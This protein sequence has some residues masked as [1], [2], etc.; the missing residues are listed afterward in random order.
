VSDDGGDD[1]DRGEDDAGS[2]DRGEGDEPIES[3]IA[4][5]SHDEWLDAL[6]DGEG[7]AMRCP[8][9]HAAL[10]P[11]VVCPDCGSSDL[12]KERL[13]PTGTVETFTVVHVGAPEFAA[14]VPY[15]TA[16]AAFGP[17]RLTGLLR[18]VE[19]ADE[20]IPIGLEVEAGV[21]TRE[22]GGRAV[23]LRPVEMP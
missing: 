23:A 19:A 6:A 7:Y 14:D 9:G 21:E 13:P 10:P 11:R 16:I 17:V 4:N 12:S 20:A 22:D 1:L 8:N 15:V 2:V 18:G 5:T 3:R